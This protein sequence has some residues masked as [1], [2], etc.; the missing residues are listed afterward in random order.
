MKPDRIYY[1]KG[2]P[3]FHKHSVYFHLQATRL[4]LETRGF[5]PPPSGGFGFSC[6]LSF[7]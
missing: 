2:I 6:V 1:R 5:P 7:P 3:P 4:S